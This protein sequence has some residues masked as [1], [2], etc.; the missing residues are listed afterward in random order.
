MRSFLIKVLIRVINLLHKQSS[1]SVGSSN[2]STRVQWI[3]QALRK[4][5]E[6][7]KLLDA[8]AGEQQ[9]R[10]FCDHLNYTSQDFNQYDGKGDG[11]GLHTDQWDTSRIEIVSDI[12]EIPVD[13]GSFDAIMC[14]EVLEHVPDP[15]ATLREFDRILKPGGYL[16]I[17]APFCSMT[18]FAPYHFSTGFNRYFYEH[19]MKELEFEILDLEANGTYYDYLAQEIRRLDSIAR[20]HNGAVTDSTYFLAKRFMMQFLDQ[21]RRGDQT[22]ELMCFGYHLFAQKKIK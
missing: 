4:V 2:E 13:K 7:S 21:S 9:F 17:T 15:V 12:T 19:W 10:R 6:G 3:E 14:T 8:G 20:D 16:L 5:P 1:L 18:H 11:S 22:S